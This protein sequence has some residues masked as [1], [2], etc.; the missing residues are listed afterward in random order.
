MLFIG[1]DRF[2]HDDRYELISSRHGRWT[3]KL[4]YVT[5]RDAG[6]FECQVSTVPKLNQTFALRVVG[7]RY[8][9]FWHFLQSIRSLVAR[10]LESREDKHRKLEYFLLTQRQYW[11]SN[12]KRQKGNRRQPQ[13]QLGGQPTQALFAEPETEGLIGIF[14]HCTQYCKEHYSMYVHS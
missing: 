11:Y 10:I 12:I 14:C 2:V 6:R 5:A 7:K 8:I 9:L 1:R 3:L 4:K 13:W